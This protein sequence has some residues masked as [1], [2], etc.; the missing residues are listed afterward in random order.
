MQGVRVIALS[1]FDEPTIAQKV[2]AAGAARY[3]EKGLAMNLAG[4]IS[5]VLATT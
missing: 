1:G 4:V 2:L 3:V 5:E